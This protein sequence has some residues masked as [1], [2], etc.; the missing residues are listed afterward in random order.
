MSLLS[1]LPQ[2]I[3]AIGG[4]GTAAF[5]LVDAT[6]V[7]KGGVNR[8]GF[9]RIEAAVKTLTPGVPAS[10]LSQ[11]RILATLR[12][13]WYNGKHLEDQKSIAKSLIKVS[14]SAVNASAVAKATGQDAAILSE[15]ASNIT[16]GTPLSQAQSDVYARFDFVVTALLDEVYQDADQSFTNGAR[17]VAA[18]FALLL[19]VAGGWTLVGGSFVTYVKSMPMLQALA[20]G[21]LAIPLAPIA[22]NLSSALVAAVNTMQVLKK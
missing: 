20:V 2:V 11:E 5:G 21:L 3:T 1:S 16:T 10:G 22:K 12:A 17:T 8:F 14:L 18:I 19:A 7:F 13:N 6:K 15:V 9:A 4:L